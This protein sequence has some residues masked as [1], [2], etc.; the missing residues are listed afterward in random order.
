MK[1]KGEIVLF[2]QGRVLEICQG[3]RNKHWMKLKFP[4]SFTKLSLAFSL[5]LFLKEKGKIDPALSGFEKVRCSSTLSTCRNMAKS[6][7]SFSSEVFISSEVQNQFREL[8][9][10][11]MEISLLPCTDFCDMLGKRTNNVKQKEEEPK[12][13]LLS[14]I[15]DREQKKSTLVLTPKKIKLYLILMILGYLAHKATF[16][17]CKRT[18]THHQDETKNKLT[19]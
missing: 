9:K 3:K 13:A 1:E 16:C 7:T 6:E 17:D 8:K 12:P 2:Y 10:F 18:F 19:S 15:L 11:R 5:N 4:P 14:K